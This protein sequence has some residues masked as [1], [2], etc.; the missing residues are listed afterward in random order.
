MG[1]LSLFLLSAG[2]L[3]ARFI[4][5]L[6]GV[7]CSSCGVLAVFSFGLFESVKSKW[8]GGAFFWRRKEGLTWDF[9]IVTLTRVESRWIVDLL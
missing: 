2:G 4:F 9:D 8:R 7:C 3:R 5:V 6:S 1:F